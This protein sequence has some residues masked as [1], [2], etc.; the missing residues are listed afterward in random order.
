MKFQNMSASLVIGIALLLMACGDGNGNKGTSSG[1]FVD[2]PVDGLHFTTSSNPMG[3]F[4]SGGGHFE[5]QAGDTVMFFIGTRQ[6]GNPQPCPSEFVTAVSVLGASSVT[7]PEVIN[8]A[9][10]L[11]TLATSVTSTLLT[12]PQPL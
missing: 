9:Q 10:L 1:I 3:G 5:C 12:L 2:S 4:T 6:I 11:M 8:L 7:A